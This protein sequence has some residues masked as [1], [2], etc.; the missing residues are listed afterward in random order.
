[1]VQA[2]RLPE[3]T[4]ANREVVDL[5]R[6]VMGMTPLYKQR[7]TLPHSWL[8]SITEAYTDSL[9]SRTPPKGSR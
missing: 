6:E 9:P 7:N 4:R 5:V 2:K 1:V 3:E 8:S